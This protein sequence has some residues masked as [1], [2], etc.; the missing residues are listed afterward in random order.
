MTKS[1]HAAVV[2]TRLAL[3]PHTLRLTL[4]GQSLVGLAS[5]PAQDVELL[6]IDGIGPPLTRAPQFSSRSPGV[7]RDRHRRSAS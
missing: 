2:R 5:L 3:T 4:G 7:R 6:V 1:R